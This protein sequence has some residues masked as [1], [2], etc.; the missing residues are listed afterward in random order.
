MSTFSR[1]YT[2]G[3]KGVCENQKFYECT[4]LGER[5]SVKINIGMIFIIFMGIFGTQEMLMCPFG[6]GRGV[7]ESVQSVH[8]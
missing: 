6:G 7:L 5:G 1:V 8:S 2:F 3:G 4:L